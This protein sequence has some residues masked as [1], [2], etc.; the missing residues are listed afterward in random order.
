MS[1][2]E[3]V[4]RGSLKL[5]G[6]S[7]HE[8]KKKKKKKEKKL[9]E[10]T[11]VV[12]SDDARKQSTKPANTKTK[13]ELAFEKMQEKRKEERIKARA[14]KTHKQR[15]EE[16]NRHLDSLTEHFDIP[17][18][19]APESRAGNVAVVTGGSCG[20]GL[21]VV[22][23]L[24]QNGMHVIVGTLHP[25]EL[26]REFGDW[27]K[28]S[29]SL[30]SV[31]CLQLDLRSF[32][33]VGRFCDEFFKM[34]LPLNYL[35]NCAG[36]MLVPQSKTRDG[37]EVH[38]Q[39]NYLSHFLLT[40]SLYPALKEGSSLSFPSRVVNVSSCTHRFSRGKLD[41]FNFNAALAYADSK[42]FQVAA[43]KA[44]DEEMRQRAGYASSPVEFVSLHP[45]I[46]STRLYQHA[47]WFNEFTKACMDCILMSPEEGSQL[48]LRAVFDVSHG[49]RHGIYLESNRKA[50]THPVVHQ[51]VFRRKLWH[52]TRDLLRLDAD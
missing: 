38:L 49:S 26:E 52:L 18:V 13:A 1:E 7:E 29:K 40:H 20:I 17:K 31:D 9:L 45:G 16:F 41:D 4:A 48:V 3:K 30:G 14:G 37:F 36:L 43:T 51:R 33:S 2:Y 35:I 15:V 23:S 6:V 19:S 25:N 34:Q 5:K 24:V 11:K 27:K 8:I 10:V 42:L 50:S 12:P 39:V 47:W 21:A 32:E 44:W 46:C 28:R 22:K